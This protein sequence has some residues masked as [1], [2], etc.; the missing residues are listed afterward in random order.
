[1]FLL[2]MTMWLENRVLN[3][4]GKKLSSYFTFSRIDRFMMGGFSRYESQ[5]VANS[6]GPDS[7]DSVEAVRNNEVTSITSLVHILLC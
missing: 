2:M 7:W 4:G 1:M 5:T 6:Y 3:G